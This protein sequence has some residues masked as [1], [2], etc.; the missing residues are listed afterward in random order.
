MLPSQR[1]PPLT[2][3]RSKRL[4]FFERKQAHTRRDV[5]SEGMQGEDGKIERAAR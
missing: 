5:S 2:Q 4:P 3:G 1:L